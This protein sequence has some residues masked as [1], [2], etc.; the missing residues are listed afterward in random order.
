VWPIKQPPFAIAWF[1][2]KNKNWVQA[3]VL[4]LLTSQGFIPCIAIGGRLGSAFAG[5]NDGL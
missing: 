4:Q 5:S 2:M 1:G 3:F